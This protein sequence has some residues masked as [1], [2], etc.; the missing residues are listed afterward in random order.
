MNGVSNFAVTDWEFILNSEFM[1]QA[2]VD[3]ATKEISGEDFKSLATLSGYG[4]IVRNLIRQRGVNDARKVS[5]KALRR[6]SL[7]V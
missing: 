3:F 2:T 4:G 1:Q 6:R 7:L 5:R